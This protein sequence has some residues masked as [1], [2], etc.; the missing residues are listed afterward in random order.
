MMNFRF[1]VC[2][3]NIWTNT[4]WAERRYPLQQFATLNRPDLLCLQEV[5]AESLQALDEVLL[6]T[7]QRVQDDFAGWTCEGNLY[8]RSDMFELVEHGAEQIGIIEQFRRLFWARLALKDGSG[9]TI[10]VGT[11]HL[12]YSLHPQT[13]ADEKY[14][15]IAQAKA[16]LAA[17]NTLAKDDE[18]QLLMG[19]FNDQSAVIKILMEG[20]FRDCFSQLGRQ[21]SIT[22]P[23]HPAWGAGSTID[24][25]M[26]RGN[27]IA[28]LTA[29]VINFFVN[30]MPPSDHKPLMATYELR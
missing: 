18:P 20:D 5:T 22:H 16:T 4:R 21:T 7:H 24:W 28:P 6:S 17:M 14:A 2:T 25:L 27:T 1:T 15:R 19:D 29:D 30:D 11:M 9:R 13:L 10:L 12:T 26:S 8:W 23:A 3:Y